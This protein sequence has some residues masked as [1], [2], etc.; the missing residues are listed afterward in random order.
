M[1]GASTEGANGRA[2]HRHFGRVRRGD[3]D[4]KPEDIEMNPRTLATRN[5]FKIA[6]RQSWKRDCSLKIS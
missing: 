6:F 5:C 3:A 1:A 2:G 4:A